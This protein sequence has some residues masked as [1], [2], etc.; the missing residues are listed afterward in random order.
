MCN[1]N[2][3]RRLTTSFAPKALALGLVAFLLVVCSACSSGLSNPNSPSAATSGAPVAENSL[4]LVFAPTNGSTLSYGY[5]SMF[6]VAYSLSNNDVTNVVVWVCVSVD[7]V[8]TTTSGDCSGRGGLT[9]NPGTIDIWGGLGNTN[10]K[11]TATH[12]VVLE[13]YRQSPGSSG[14]GELLA[15]PTVIPM[16][17][18][19]QK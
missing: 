2:V 12:Y 11:I 10:S 8:N 18:T 1:W 16:D 15:G 7:G 13:V 4:K 9:T 17:Y 3:V 6:T 5:S 19:Y 14:F